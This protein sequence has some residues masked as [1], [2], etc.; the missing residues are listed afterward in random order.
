MS[1]TG[2]FFTPLNHIQRAKRLAQI[3]LDTALSVKGK[4]FRKQSTMNISLSAYK[5]VW[6][7]WF[8]SKPACSKGPLWRFPSVAVGDYNPAGDVHDK[9]I[10]EEKS[11]NE[12]MAHTHIVYGGEV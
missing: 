4:V 11:E 8:I 1:K 6:H 10:N 2:A 5:Y 9:L 3:R 12:H 7:F